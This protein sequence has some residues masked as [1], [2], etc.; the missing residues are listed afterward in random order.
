MS[1]TLSLQR[2]CMKCSYVTDVLL[3]ACE[4]YELNISYSKHIFCEECFRNENKNHNA[5]MNKLRCP[6][7]QTQY[8]D[9]FQSIEEAVLIGAGAYFYYKFYYYQH[10]GMDQNL[11]HNTIKQVIE[12]FE[13]ALKRNQYNKASLLCLIRALYCAHS[14]YMKTVRFRVT[15]TN[16]FIP[17]HEHP[18]EDYPY[19][20]FNA[21]F[22]LF[23]LCRSPDGQLLI[24]SLH[25]YYS[26][27]GMVFF[28]GNNLPVAVKY[29][30]MAY[31]SCLRSADHTCLVSRKQHYLKL[32]YE[33]DM[34]PPLRFAIGDA[35]EFLYTADT[36]SGTSEWKR[37]K[38]V[39]LYYH[40]VFVYPLVP[41]IAYSF[42]KTLTLPTSLL[43]MLGSRLT[44]IAM[45]ARWASDR[46]RALAIRPDWMLR[47]QSW[48]MYTAL[49]SSYMAYT[50][51]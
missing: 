11:L 30:K 29:N 46:S 8:Y 37:G 15:D 50:A 35:V 24:D 31:E 40:E 10:Q 51:H 1:R 18:V 45:S 13:N 9:Y 32:K 22:D 12:K 2:I 33:F 39:E 49:R 28:D 16:S 47:S 4:G 44:S 25:D 5:L 14:Q 3:R 7:C 6:C 23:D 48:L 41:L 42:S 19:R 20:M 26:M 38:V 17:T 43:Y 21:C 36:G 34:L 27:L